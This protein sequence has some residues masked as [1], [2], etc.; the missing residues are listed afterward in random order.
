MNK[1]QFWI[2]NI[3][4]ALLAVLFI[5]STRMGEYSVFLLE[6]DKE[7]TFQIAVILTFIVIPLGMYAFKRFMTKANKSD[8]ASFEKGYFGVKFAITYMTSLCAYIHAVLFYATENR[9]T[10]YCALIFMLFSVY[11][12]PTA[13][14]AQRTFEANNLE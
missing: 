8:K 3:S 7:Y 4:M 5:S 11:T 12:Y 1:R 10:L 14:G 13:R 2:N 6:Q 9:S